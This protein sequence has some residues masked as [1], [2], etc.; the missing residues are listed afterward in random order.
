M[1]FFWNMMCAPAAPDSAGVASRYFV[2]KPAFRPPLINRGYFSRVIFIRRLI[3]QFL[4][5]CSKCK[6]AEQIVSLGA[7]MDTNFFNLKSGV[8]GERPPRGGYFEVDMQ[9]VVAKKRRIILNNSELRALALGPGATAGIETDVEQVLSSRYPSFPSAS[10]AA[11]NKHQP[12]TRVDGWAYFFQSP[13]G[14]RKAHRE[15]VDC[16]RKSMTH[17]RFW[18]GARWGGG[19][20]CESGGRWERHRRLAGT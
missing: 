18:G 11:C 1:K 17:E 16:R 9:A 10:A 12:V 5:A 15:L 19:C 6:R 3:S 8:F 14:E 7:G 2:G 4:S 13:A 20:P